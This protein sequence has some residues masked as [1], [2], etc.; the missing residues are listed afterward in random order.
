MTVSGYDRETNLNGILFDPNI[1]IIVVAKLN[2]LKRITR[3]RPNNGQAFD[4][5]RTVY[6]NPGSSDT[7]ALFSQ[8]ESSGEYSDSI[9]TQRG[10]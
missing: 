4:P 10:E 6:I 7:L 1:G 5:I 3:Y 8:N 2:R 9:L